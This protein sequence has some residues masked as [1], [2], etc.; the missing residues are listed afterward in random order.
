MNS[1]DTRSSG[2][3][4]PAAGDQNGITPTRPYQPPDSFSAARRRQG[5]KKAAILMFTGIALVAF[6][7]YVFDDGLNSGF[8]PDRKEIAVSVI[9]MLVGSTC[10]LVLS[11]LKTPEAK[12]F[13]KAS[14]VL[15]VVVSTAVLAL[16]YI[17][18]AGK[19]KDETW[20]GSRD[21]TEYDGQYARVRCPY[22]EH[23]YQGAVGAV[24][25]RTKKEYI[26]QARWYETGIYVDYPVADPNDRQGGSR[27]ERT[28]MPRKHLLIIDP[29]QGEIRDLRGP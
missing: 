22:L 26:R 25:G 10:L 6:A 5:V 16:S 17:R 13:F 20:F 8:A 19:Y 7:L 9:S 24:Y 18:Y 3:E 28:L 15:T 14:A 21:V 1:D 12:H 27:A 4:W 29:G 2:G 11:S 23:H